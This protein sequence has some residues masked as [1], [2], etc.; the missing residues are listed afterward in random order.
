MNNKFKIYIN[1]MPKLAFRL[2]EYPLTN[3]GDFKQLPKAGGIY[4]LY[5]NNKPIY[6]G[7]YGYSISGFGILIG[8]FWGFVEGFV[9]LGIFA[10]IYNYLQK[11]S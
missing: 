8:A 11:K 4:V 6:D 7:F 5:E 10:L 1:Q 2:S 9:H 3:W